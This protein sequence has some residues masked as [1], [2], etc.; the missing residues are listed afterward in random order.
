M[1]IL[2][3]Q[4]FIVLLDAFLFKSGKEMEGVEMIRLILIAAFAAFA[5][6]ALTSTAYSAGEREKCG[7]LAQIPCDQGLW[8][9]VKSN[10]PGEC[11]GVDLE[12]TCKNLKTDCK[13]FIEECG[14][15]G[16]TYK[17]ECDR[18]K[19]KVQL[20]HVGACKP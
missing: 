11:G 6:F 16:N 18:V 13:S 9:D 20:K 15:D 7:T 5:G 1:K 10:K 12:G 4:I 14:C 19:A 2:N 8:C 3:I 17:S